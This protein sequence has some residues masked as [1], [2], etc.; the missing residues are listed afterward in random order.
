MRIFGRVSGLSFA[1]LRLEIIN[2]A[3]RLVLKSLHFVRV[4]ALVADSFCC[5]FVLSLP[6]FQILFV[7]L[8]LLDPVLVLINFAL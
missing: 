4:G 6:I 7:L 5:L 3:K 1:W 2:L 8:Q